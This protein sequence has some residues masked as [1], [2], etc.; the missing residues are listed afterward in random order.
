MSDRDEQYNQIW[1]A[2]QQVADKETEIARLSVALEE[3]RDLHQRSQSRVMEL[4]SGLRQ[5]KRDVSIRE[6][7]AAHFQSEV[8]QDRG[9][10]LAENVDLKRENSSLISELKRL[11]RQRDAC[12][13]SLNTGQ[14]RIQLIAEKIEQIKTGDISNSDF[15]RE[16]FI[17]Q[18]DGT[19]DVSLRAEEITACLAATVKDSLQ[20]S[21]TESHKLRSQVLQLEGAKESEAAFLKARIVALERLVH[22]AF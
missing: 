19:V 12:L 14:M 10:V 21:Q 11:E 3:S 16:L 8:S 7:N 6:Q 13:A 17:S 18:H 15:K 1:T 2:K 4:E 20:E 9:L 5:I 22:G